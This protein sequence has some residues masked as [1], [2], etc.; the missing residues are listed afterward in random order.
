MKRPGAN[1]L[2]P[3]DVANNT[4]APDTQSAHNEV[5]F[6][7]ENDEALVR[8]DPNFDDIEEETSKLSSGSSKDGA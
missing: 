8:I 7:F 4:N 2:I 3:E 1:K 5:F 6:T